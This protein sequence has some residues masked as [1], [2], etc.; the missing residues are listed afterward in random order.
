MVS[1]A[2][3]SRGDFLWLCVLTKVQ[4][5]GVE[6]THPGFSLCVCLQVVELEKKIVKQRDTT[7]RMLEAKSQKHLQKKIELLEIR[8]SHVRKC[9]RDFWRTC[10]GSHRGLGPFWSGQSTVVKMYLVYTSC[11]KHLVCSPGLIIPRISQ[12]LLQAW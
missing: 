3:V 10:V 1:V 9:F 12:R 8:L 5:I 11:I 7:W 6:I 2:Q 4:N